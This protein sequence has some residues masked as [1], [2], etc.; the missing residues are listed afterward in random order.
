[1]PT[2]RRSNTSAAFIPTMTL[3]A[4][5]DRAGD[6]REHSSVASAGRSQGIIKK[7]LS[8]VQFIKKTVEV[9]RREK[10]QP[11]GLFGVQLT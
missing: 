11:E 5:Q 10:S 8:A 6:S 4:L 3:K 9:L 1:M 7:D 2:H